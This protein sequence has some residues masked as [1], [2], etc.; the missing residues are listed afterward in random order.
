[1]SESVL[2]QGAALTL[3]AF[4][5]PSGVRLE[6]ELHHAPANELGLTMIAELEVVAKAVQARDATLSGLLF[7]STLRHGFSA[8]A[9]LRE[10]HL[11][12]E[13]AKARGR[14]VEERTR[15][16]G[17]FLDDIHRLFS[18]F[19]AA[20][21]TTVSVV[22]GVVFGGGLELM[23]TSDIVIAEKSAR[24]AFPE[25]RLGLIPGFGGIPR[26]KRDVG[27]AVVRDL[28]LTGRS[29]GAQ[30]AHDV[31]LVSQLVAE[32]RGLEVGRRTLEQAAKFDRTTTRVAKRFTKPLPKDE[33]AHEKNLF[34]TL[35]RSPTVERALAEFA[36]SRDAMPYLP[37][38]GGPSESS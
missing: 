6:V 35:F 27:N 1:M 29:L 23:L 32:G 3:R 10:L 18:T 9:D 36:T 13:E 21:C 17:R 20:P 24:F 33:L 15:E 25:L 4:E 38:G 5:D 7:Y 22:H 34:L 11:R 14:S 26:L 16:V 12:I 8:G 2:H 28:L 30:R 31:G 37:T 19:D